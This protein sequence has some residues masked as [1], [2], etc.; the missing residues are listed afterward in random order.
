[1]IKVA[2]LGENGS[3][4]IQKWVK[5]ISLYPDVELHVI[6]F[7]RGVQFENVQYHNLDILLNN[8]ID[9]LLNVRNVKKI[10]T[11]IKPD[12]VH[13]H[14]ATSYGYIGSKLNFHPFIITGWGADIFD[15]PKN[16]ILKSILIKS[17]KQADAITV[18][19]KITKKEIQKLTTK[20]VSLIPFGVDINKFKKQNN[21]DDGLIRI[22]T[23]RTLTEKYGVEYLVR[24]FA[25]ICHKYQNARLEI[26]GDGPLRQSLEAL[27]NDL[28]I[29]EKVKFYGYIN[30]NEDFEKYIQLLSNFDIFAILSVLDSE[31]FGVASVE[32][33]SCSVPVIATHVGGLPEV[34]SDNKTGILVPPR[35]VE[36]TAKAIERLIADKDLREEMGRNG[37]IKVEQEYDWKQNVNN[38]I[39][40]YRKL[41]NERLLL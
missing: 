36:Q 21:V 24:A 4:H 5:A 31:T 30:Q 28:G 15:S 35:N 40:L 17:F 22:G 19:S 2:L 34:V 9:Y 41:I 38:M 20:E 32:A 39:A 29:S 37:R 1:M 8:K 6:S 33:S 27:C 3:V 10:I 16:P 23:I 14:Y 25:L 12:L 11:K 7:N 18:L 26:V 13:A